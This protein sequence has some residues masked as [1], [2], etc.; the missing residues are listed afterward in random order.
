MKKR[1]IGILLTIVMLTTMLPGFDTGV[2]AEGLA[3]TVYFKAMIRC[4]E[5]QALR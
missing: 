1:I 5:T 4:S 3:E 2:F